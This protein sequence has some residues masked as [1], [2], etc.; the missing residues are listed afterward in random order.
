MVVLRPGNRIGPSSSTIRA[1]DSTELTVNRVGAKVSVTSAPPREIH[2][3]MPHVTNPM[4]I[5]NAI[6]ASTGT[7]A[8]DQVDFN[9][10][11]R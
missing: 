8:R 6:P 11:G 4:K 10:T 3:A 7:R 9:L 5:R 1:A 2:A